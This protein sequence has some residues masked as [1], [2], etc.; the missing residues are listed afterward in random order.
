MKKTSKSIKKKC[1]TRSCNNLVATP[2]RKCERCKAAARRSRNAGRGR[3][4][5]MRM[6]FSTSGATA[7]IS[8]QTPSDSPS[9]NPSAIA[10]RQ[11]RKLEADRVAGLPTTRDEMYDWL[12]DWLDVPGNTIELLEQRLGARAADWF[13]SHPGKTWADMADA[14]MAINGQ[15]EAREICDTADQRGFFVNPVTRMLAR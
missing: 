7:A 1:S 12:Y 6:D 2:A 8:S 14:V 5:M 9:S 15:I 3:P 13:S 11:S 10:D 4:A